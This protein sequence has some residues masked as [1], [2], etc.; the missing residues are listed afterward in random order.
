MLLATFWVIFS[1]THL[2]NLLQTVLYI[3]FW[4]HFFASTVSLLFPSRI[5]FLANKS[6]KKIRFGKQTK[7]KRFFFRAQKKARFSRARARLS[8]TR[9][10]R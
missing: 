9:V 7:N 1:Q 5:S 2:V 8:T 6:K 3:S 10:T 4:R